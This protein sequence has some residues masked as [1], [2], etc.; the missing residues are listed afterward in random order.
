MSKYYKVLGVSKDATQEDIKKAYK[1]LALRYHP[2]RN[3][4]NR[5]EA[6]KKFKEVSEAHKILSDPEKRRE[7][8][9]TGMVSDGFS[10][11]GGQH[12][13][14][15]MFNTIFK[16]HVSE[17]VNN[18]PKN[19]NNFADILNGLKG[20]MPF[21]GIRF[22]INTETSQK[23]K[24]PKVTKRPKTELIKPKEY[25]VNKEFSMEDIYKGTTQSVAV[26][27]TRRF[28]ENGKIVYKKVTKKFNIPL[29]GREIFV[30]NSGN[31][32]K[33]YKKPADLLI[34]IKDKLN[35]LFKRANDY[36][37]LM[38]HTVS[39]NNLPKDGT[40]DLKLP[41]GRTV[42][43][44]IDIEKIL[45][46]GNKLIKVNNLGLPFIINNE[47]K[48]G[49]LYVKLNIVYPDFKKEETNDEESNYKYI[50]TEL[51]NSF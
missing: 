25:V 27:L 13:P 14:F 45:K 15:E 51:I 43:L 37:L 12:N 24:V 23:N 16:K 11:A 7:Y 35:P 3:I 8:D 5:E 28:K 29:K 17:F 26:E 30:E 4:N 18:A 20:D 10:M 39:Y 21:G 44:K 2:D 22:K 32:V 34:M 9:T 42:H 46:E 40:L 19:S 41:D 33:G 50:E 36:D 1:K 48:R 49:K 38:N 31:H 6:S 47:V